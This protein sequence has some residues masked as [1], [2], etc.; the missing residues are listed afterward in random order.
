MKKTKLVT[1]ADIA[2]RSGYAIGTVYHF[3]LQPGFP[4]AIARTLP[5][6]RD[7]AKVDR[8]FD[9]HKLNVIKRCLRGR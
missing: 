2:K 3:A 1:Y 8:W 7:A 5:Q 9:R 6:K 4:K